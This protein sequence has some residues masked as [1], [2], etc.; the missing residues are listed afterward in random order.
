MRA[1]KPLSVSA[2]AGA[3]SFP[4]SFPAPRPSPPVAH[5]ISCPP[6]LSPPSLPPALQSPISEHV[7]RW[8]HWQHQPLDMDR[9]RRWWRLLLCSPSPWFRFRRR[10]RFRPAPT[11][12]D[13]RRTG[14]GDHSARCEASGSQIETCAH[15]QGHCQGTQGLSETQ[16]GAGSEKQTRRSAERR[17]ADFGLGCSNIEEIRRPHSC[18]ICVPSLCA[19]CCQGICGVH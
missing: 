19:L 6:S 1:R 16:C 15:S 5:F 13:A 10:I 9:R 18:L 8:P 11:N 3:A 17:P 14:L 12:R 7:P 4:T 2:S